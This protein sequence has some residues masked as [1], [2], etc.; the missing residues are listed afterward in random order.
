VLPDRID[1]P[2]TDELRGAMR[3]GGS[4]RRSFFEFGEGRRV[5]EEKWPAT[6]SAALATA[7]MTMPPTL[8]TYMVQRIRSEIDAVGAVA[9]SEMVRLALSQ[10]IGPAAS[11]VSRG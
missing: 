5:L 9:T 10:A 2:A 11:V 6:A 3:T 4:G 7:V 1:P 8:R